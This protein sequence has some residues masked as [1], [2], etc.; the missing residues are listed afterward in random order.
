MLFTFGRLPGPAPGPPGP[1]RCDVGQ[2]V[3][4]PAAANTRPERAQPVMTLPC[5]RHALAPGENAD[6]R[7]RLAGE[8]FS[9]V[10]RTR[11]PSSPAPGIRCRRAWR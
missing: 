1:S 4:A 11:R 8:V 9:D 7:G 10:R 5:E 2:P 3:P 6:V